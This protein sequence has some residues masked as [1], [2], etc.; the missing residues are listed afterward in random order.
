MQAHSEG[1]GDD[2]EDF[3]AVDVFRHVW[4]ALVRAG[5]GET[6]RSDRAGLTLRQL[7]ILLASDSDPELQTVRGLAARLRVSR[8]SVTLSVDQLSVMGLVERQPDPRDR[9][10]I[11]IVPT[12]AGGVLVDAMVQAMAQRHPQRANEQDTDQSASTAINRTLP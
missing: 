9:R 1:P 8:S 2:S 3:K 11:F 10:S 12:P 7:A 4:I 6:G 5:A